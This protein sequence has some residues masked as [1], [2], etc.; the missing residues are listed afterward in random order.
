MRLFIML[1]FFSVGFIC[2]SIFNFEPFSY[3]FG[4]AVTE[5][6]KFMLRMY[7]KAKSQAEA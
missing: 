2:V 5:A 6:M 3:L 4:I 1:L 7:G